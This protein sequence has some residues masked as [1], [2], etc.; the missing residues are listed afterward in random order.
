V[1]NLR[2]LP[3]GVVLA[4][5]CAAPA[6][7]AD[8]VTP[9]DAIVQGS[10]CAG[11]DCLNG[12]SF[13]FDTLRLKEN[14]LRL[15]FDDTSA[16]GFPN[17]DWAIAANDTGSGGASY[18]A[19]EDVTGAKVPFRVMAGAPTDSLTV[20][21]AGKLG[22]GTSTPLLREHLR[23]GDTP[24]IR[25]EQDNAGGY[26]PQTWDIGANEANFFVRDLTGGSRLPFRIRPGAPTSALDIAASGNTGIGTPSPLS[27]LDVRGAITQLADPDPA[28]TENTAAVDPSAILAALRTLPLNTREYVGDATDAKHLWPT[29]HDFFTAFGLGQDN[30]VVSPTDV[31][32][33]ALASVQALDAKLTTLALAKGDKGDAGAAGA[34]GM[35]GPAGSKGADGASTNTAALLKRLTKLERGNAT[36]ARRVR[37]LEKKLRPKRKATSKK[38]ATPR[39][40]GTARAT[41]PAS[42]LNNGRQG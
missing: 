19:F 4:L 14:N 18:L 7:R 38:K 28:V 15:A 6:A 35:A 39:S 22:L 40:R 21:A 27:K 16:D 1:R 42:I 34:P 29:G 17:N 30:A 3:L 33:V 12:E 13:G 11:L 26:T 37:A 41:D 36:L 8:V 2:V 31:A 5:M 32:G 20:D 24:A 23:Q 10:L 9:D 25:L